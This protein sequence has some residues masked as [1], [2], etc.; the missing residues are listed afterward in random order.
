MAK[1]RIELNTAGVRELL[2]GAEIQ[3]ILEEIAEPIMGRLPEGY[4]KDVH[5]GTNRCN[6]GIVA[7]TAEAVQDNLENNTLIKAVW[8]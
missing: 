6:V 3:G 1:V 2:R 5:V 8:K 4:R 7:S